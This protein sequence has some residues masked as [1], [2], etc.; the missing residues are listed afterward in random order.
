[1][2]S[3]KTYKWLTVAC[4]A[5]LSVG[6]LAG[7]GGNKESG[8]TVSKKE[9]KLSYVEWDSE[10]SSTNVIAKV[11][12]DLGYK[13]TV[14]PLDNA[15][16]WQAV[17]TGKS[18]GMVSAWLPKT[19]EQTYAK[20]KND[21]IDVGIN[22]SGAKIGLVVPQYMNVNSIEGLTSEANKKITGIEPG[23]GVVQA[24]ENAV[25]EYSN[26][27]GWQV[28]TSSSGA[29]VTA[30]GKSIASKEDI[31]ITGWTP[32]WMFSKY[33]LKYLDDP[34]GV[35]GGTEEIHTIVRK[36][37][38]EDNPEVYSILSNFKWDVADIESVMADIFTNHMTP[39]AAAE[40]WVKNN[41]DTV[42]SWTKGINK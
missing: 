34:K 23:A 4:I 29:M 30:L 17:A 20:Y 3:R 41:P 2:Y 42:K 16:M 25:K 27:A 21:V 5:L 40:K 14:T 15:V 24:A 33:E 32:H 13:V 8:A 10:V 11:L 26:L 39:E 37:L 38:K 12:R 22:L 35:F 19:H 36:G 18:D 28:D 9:V 7:C 6:F 1:M 31:I